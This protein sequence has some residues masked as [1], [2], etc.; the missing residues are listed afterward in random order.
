MLT[1]YQVILKQIGKS[2]RT[3]EMS[4]AQVIYK[5]GDNIST[6]AIYN[7][8]C[9]S[10]PTDPLKTNCAFTNIVKLN[11][12][13]L[14]KIPN[15]PISIVCGINFGCG[16]FLQAAVNALTDHLPELY[17]ISNSVDNGFLANSGTF[18][19]HLIQCPTMNLDDVDI[20]DEMEIQ[21]FKVINKTKNIVYPIKP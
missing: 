13:L 12:L 8:V 16:K 7:G 6:D 2:Q 5:L 3:K 4:I 15:K 20:N 19:T 21:T 18:K 14:N 17:I 11:D 1:F 9:K 10:N